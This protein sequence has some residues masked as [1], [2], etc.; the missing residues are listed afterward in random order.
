MKISTETYNKM[1]A[2][3]EF[4]A[5]ETNFYIQESPAHTIVDDDAG[6]RARDALQYAQ[7]EAIENGVVAHG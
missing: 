2:A 7:D 6:M 3:L 4:Y 1:V 5:E